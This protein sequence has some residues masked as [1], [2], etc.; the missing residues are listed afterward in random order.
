[1][2]G[3]AK[4]GLEPVEKLAHARVEVEEAAVRAERS[5][6]LHDALE[7]S[8][9]SGAVVIDRAEVVVTEEQASAGL[10]GDHSFDHPS[11][12]V[13]DRKV[14]GEGT[15]AGVLLRFEQTLALMCQNQQFAMR[16]SE[17]ES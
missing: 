3:M 16:Q 7:V 15:E 8:A 2:R 1:M 9:A 14:D 5:A 11:G 10:V 6:V 17:K 12:A 13:H 4:V